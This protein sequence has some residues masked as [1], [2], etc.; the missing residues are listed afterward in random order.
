MKNLQPMDFYCM[1]V[2]PVRGGAGPYLAF[3]F[4]SYHHWSAGTIGFMLGSMCLAFAITQIP[5]GLIVDRSSKRKLIAVSVLSVVAVSLCVVGGTEAFVPTLLAQIAIGVACAFF[6][7]LAASLSLTQ[8]ERERLNKRLGRNEICCHT[9]NILT[10]ILLGV[11]L[12]FSDSRSIVVVM[13]VCCVLAMCAILRVEEKFAASLLS[14][15]NT[16]ELNNGNNEQSTSSVTAPFK[17]RLRQKLGEIFAGFTNLGSIPGAKPFVLAA[18]LYSF[19]NA[20][21]LPLMIQFI[22]KYGSNSAAVRLPCALLIAELVMIPVC[23]TATKFS[24]VGRKPLL[25]VSF[26]LL[27]ARG[28][29]FSLVKDPDIL[30]WLQIL[31]GMSAGIFTFL[32]TL[33]V[34]DLTRERGRLSSTYCSLILMTTA[35]NAIS[36]F[37]CGAL[38]SHFG[39]QTAFSILAAVAVA[40]ILVAVTLVPETA[41][42]KKMAT[43]VTY[44]RKNANGRKREHEGNQIRTPEIRSIS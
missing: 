14:E 40:G 12:R 8:V 38:A 27:A 15:S 20:A 30:V 32:A 26:A 17:V 41:E 31:D 7:P 39:Y 29:S 1:C 28:F 16:A 3:F 9:G 37:S 6:N 44:I 19:A 22:S 5:A 34:A 42:V 2:A 13:T 10:G 25:V 11:C 24:S 43:A 4:A 33:I 18:V 36:D 21:M 23:A 35:T